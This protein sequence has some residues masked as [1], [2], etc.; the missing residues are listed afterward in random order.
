MHFLVH[1]GPESYTSEVTL[2]MTPIRRQT[3][4]LAGRHISLKQPARC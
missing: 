2:H 1:D 4:D 3:E